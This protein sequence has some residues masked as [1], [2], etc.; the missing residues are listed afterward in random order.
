[1]WLLD[2]NRRHGGRLI[3]L[4]VP[5]TALW[6]NLHGGFFI[7]LVL[8]ALRTAACA[9]EAWV[10]PDIRPARRSEVFQLVLLGA[11]C[12]LASLV[13]PY[14][15]H[16]HAH[17]LETLR[18]SWITA[19]VSEFKSPTFRTEEMYH[20]MVLLFAGLA[21][22]PSLVRKKNLV[23]PLWILFLAYCSL[24]SVR[25]LTIYLLVAT[26]IIAQELS[27]WWSE[28]VAG[29]SGASLPA[30]L[31]DVSQQ[32]TSGLPGTS[33]FIP[34][35]IVTLACLPGLHWPQ[36]FPEAAVP[37]K[38]IERHAGLL[39]NG[40]VFASDQIA[41]YLIFRN[42]PSQRVFFDSRHN[43]YGEKIGNDYLTIEEGQSKWRSVLD[44]YGFNL[45]LTPVNSP[46]SSL[47][48]AAGGWRVIENN[49]KYILFERQ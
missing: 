16:L 24:T 41:D 21:L 26:P 8:L 48:Q 34:A 29:R 1:V 42:Y 44:S 6:A 36:E 19:N 5:L 47:A 11:A 37:A 35:V 33:L 13:N 49:S 9:G 46:I 43:Y 27:T 45:I 28:W 12:G 40:R 38:M 17:I 2:Y 14:G 32:L 10:W 7:F 4:L 23:E 30:M 20:F 18:S 31:N 39:A 15:W 22:L 25:H 3:W